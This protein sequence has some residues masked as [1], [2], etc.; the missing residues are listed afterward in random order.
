L[1]SVRIGSTS[2]T[3][4]EE[5]LAVQAVVAPFRWLDVAVEVKAPPLVRVRQRGPQG[6]AH[7]QQRAE[8]RDVDALATELVAAEQCGHDRLYGELRSQQ[9]GVLGADPHR[10]VT[11]PAE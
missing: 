8:E 5:Q 2:S 6:R 4:R 1:S 11:Q 9:A 7:L 10:L 3:L